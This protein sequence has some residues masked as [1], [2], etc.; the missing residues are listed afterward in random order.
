V[1]DYDFYA[2]Y[3]IRNKEYAI[4]ME[5]NNNLT[6]NE[7]LFT[8]MNDIFPLHTLQGCLLAKANH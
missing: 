2:E 4:K 6:K 3:A 8:R 1:C 7:F 5:K